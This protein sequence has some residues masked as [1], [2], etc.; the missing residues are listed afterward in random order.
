[1][2]DGERDEIRSYGAR[3]K[4]ELGRISKTCQC[5]GRIQ[6]N[7]FAPNFKLVKTGCRHRISYDTA[8]DPSLRD[9]SMVF[10]T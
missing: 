10:L 5:P 1:M 3:L 8:W 9:D 6:Q 7:S 2:K 4:N